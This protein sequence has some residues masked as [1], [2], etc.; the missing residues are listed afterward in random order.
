M[1]KNVK[2]K[3]EEM[4]RET[5]IKNVLRIYPGKTRA[6]AEVLYDKLLKNAEKNEQ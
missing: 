4:T 2:I 6:E 5:W 1:D 3:R